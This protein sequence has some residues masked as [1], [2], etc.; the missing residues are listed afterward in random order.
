[1][2]TWKKLLSLIIAVLMVL[3][4]VTGCAGKSETPPAATPSASSTASPSPTEGDAPKETSDKTYTF[5]YATVDAQGSD[6]DKMVESVLKQLLEEKSGGRM[7]LQVYYS[8][9]LTGVGS[10]LDGIK[11]G[12][13]D[14]GY[15]ACGFYAGQF[16]YTELFSTPGLYYGSNEEATDV[17]LEFMEL[18]PDKLLSDYKIMAKFVGEVMCAFSTGKPITSPA[19][20]KGMTFRTTGAN[21][22]L[23]EACGGAGTGLPSSEVYESL[24][25]NVID[26]SISNFGSLITFNFGEVTKS[27]TRMPILTSEGTVFMSKELYES[28][29]APDQAIIDEVCAEFQKA[30]MEYNEWNDQNTYDFIEANLPDFEVIELSDEAL[31]EFT[32]LGL[33]QMEAKAKELDA[34]G[35]DGTGALEWLKSQAK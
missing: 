15:D 31:A 10:T 20:M 24:R 19:D 11:N 6:H 34:L 26:G 8:G 9:S 33:T 12:T 25:L 3:I 29:P 7:T 32:A 35:L 21:T 14:M 5:T 2:S 23:I 4:T 16:P 22:K 17:L 13:V 30:F 18:Y 27:C 28:L 1:M